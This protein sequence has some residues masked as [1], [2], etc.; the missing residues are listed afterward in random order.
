MR[1]W[2]GVSNAYFS[3]EPYDG[4]CGGSG[5]LVCYC[6]GDQC[7]CHNHGEVECGGCDDCDLGDDL[8]D[9]LYDSP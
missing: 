3:D 2:C 8:G 7:V 5:T 6:G 1:C 4:G 9:D